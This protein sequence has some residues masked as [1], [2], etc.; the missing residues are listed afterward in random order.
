MSESGPTCE[1]LIELPSVDE[2]VR[3]LTGGD[4]PEA[5]WVLDEKRGN[6]GELYAIES[7]WVGLS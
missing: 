7:L 5:L 6:R 4:V 1:T 2:E 3:L